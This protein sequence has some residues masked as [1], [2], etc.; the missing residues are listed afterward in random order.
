[1]TTRIL[2]FSYLVFF[3]HPPS[4]I[5]GLYPLLPRG[6]GHVC[7]A[8]MGAGLLYHIQKRIGV[9]HVVL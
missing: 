4:L 8:C 3:G 2:L 9:L 6:F 7:F 1:M 5:A